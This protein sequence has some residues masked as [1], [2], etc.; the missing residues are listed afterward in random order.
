MEKTDRTIFENAP[1]WNFTP[2]HNDV[3]GYSLLF[4]RASPL[5][6]LLTPP[7]P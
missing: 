7:P 6:P 4:L 5:D 1:L 3:V 2:N